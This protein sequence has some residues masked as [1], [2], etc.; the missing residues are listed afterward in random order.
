MNLDLINELINKGIAGIAL[1]LIAFILVIHV[2]QKDVE[3][4]RKSK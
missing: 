4:N 3:K 2:L 1:M